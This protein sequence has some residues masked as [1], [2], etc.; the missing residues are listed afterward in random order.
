MNLV[1]GSTGMLGT[2]ICRQLRSRGHAVRAMVR[3]TSDPA[4]VAALRALGAE[5]VTGDLRDAQSLQRACAG[6]TCVINTATAVSGFTPENTFLNVDGGAKDL[7]DAAR[8]AQVAQFV[9]ISVSS[10]LNADCDLVMMKRAAEQHLINS[11]MA[12]TIF[13][14]CTFMEIWLS[15]MMGLDVANARAQVIG[16]GTA[17][18]SYISFVDVARFAVAAVG[19]PAAQ[20]LA[21]D[22]GGPDGVAPLEVVTILERLTGKRF[23][24]NHIPVE[25]LQAQH[26]AATN[27]LEKTFAALMLEVGKGDVVRMQEPLQRF[28]GIT[29]RSIEEYA[30][31]LVPLAAV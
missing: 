29:L 13:R 30:A 15:P 4:K 10:G 1:V 20:N 16:E 31:Q 28:P 24:V 8:A 9:L 22:I 11:G 26:L 19:N 3:D 12:Y 14:P 25:G 27:P 23:A 18:L 21:L 2:E 5:I 7:I 17:P 6:A